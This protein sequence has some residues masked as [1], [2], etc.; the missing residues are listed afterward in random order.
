MSQALKLGVLGKFRMH[1][2]DG[3]PV[4]LGVR[5]A[6]GLLA[7]LA[8]E[9][10]ASRDRV[11]GLFWGERNGER[12]RHNVRQVLSKIR[13]QCGPLIESDGEFLRLDT[14]R[15]AVDVAGFS[16]LAASDDAASLQRCLEIYA[17]DLLE[18]TLPKEAGF[19]EW[20]LPARERLR[21]QACDAMDRYVSILMSAGSERQALA[22]VNRR[23]SI[24][25][26]CEPA[27]RNLITILHRLGRRSDALRQ[28]D[29]CADALQRELGVAPDAATRA[30]VAGIRTA[31]GESHGAIDGGEAAGSIA[32]LAPDT[33][34]PRIAVLPFENLSAET[35]DYF[36]DGIT[37]DIITAL[38]RFHSLYVIARGSTFVYKNKVTPDDEIA[39]ALGA[40]YLVRGSVLRSGERVRINV[41]LLD[42]PARLTVWGSRFETEMTDLFRVQDEITATVV[43]TLAGR[44]EAVQLERTRKAGPQRLKAYDY[45]L[46]G[47]DHHHRFTPDDCAT[48]IDLFENAIEQDPGYAAAHAW[49]AC[50]LG[51]AMIWDLD[52]HSSLV[53]RAQAAAERGLALD[54]NDSESHR[55]L[56]QVFLTRGNL[57][58]SLQHQERALFLNP[59]DD[60]SVC[61]M[62]EILC[63]AGRHEEAEQWVRK[64][65]QLNPYHPQR[66]WTHLARALFHLSRFA[67][68][69]AVLEQIGRPR[70][71]DFAYAVAASV[72]AGNGE[73]VQ[74]N[75]DAL[76]VGVADFDA[77]T[78]VAALPYKRAADRNL[79]RDALAEAGL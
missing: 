32:M 9:G 17:G 60:R 57:P 70:K 24:D 45:V 58:R 30:L 23:L 72:R 4:A 40:R 21:R 27:H 11:A 14:D 38:S 51:Q 15:V 8:V 71:D 49:L 39:A 7:F 12:A 79:L 54:E 48:C 76:R 66:Y 78:F 1:R 62:G 20:L 52:D 50:G 68:A 26:A 13:G 61:S 29:I 19:E 3:T 46:R 35:G 36:A 42:G 5:K 63:Y 53:D 69:C 10:Q 34:A 65:M 73:A 22:A 75:V 25:P 56:A 64:A 47:K 2:A 74:R 77:A 43:A 37:E 33:N 41:Q 59:N 28:Y 31:A 16:A 55:V 67:E 44:L 18:G 6:Q